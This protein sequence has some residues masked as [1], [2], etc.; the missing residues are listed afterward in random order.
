LTIFV[1]VLFLPL[2]LVAQNSIQTISGRVLAEHPHTFDIKVLE[3]YGYQIEQFK[4]KA[5]LEGSMSNGNISARSIGNLNQ[6]ISDLQQ[7]SKGARSNLQIDSLSNAGVAS[8]PYIIT[9]PGFDPITIPGF[10]PSTTPG[11]G[12][13]KI[14]ELDPKWQLGTVPRW[15]PG[16]I[17]GW[18]P[19]EIGI[20][21]NTSPPFRFA[22]S[23]REN[24]RNPID[25]VGINTVETK[26]WPIRSADLV[27]EGTYQQG[28][29]QYDENTCSNVQISIRKIENRLKLN[30]THILEF[31]KQ[32]DL[33][34]ANHP[35]D[36]KR[37][38]QAR[39][40]YADKCLRNLTV[41]SSSIREQIANSVGFFASLENSN[42]ETFCS[43]SIVDN[44]VVLTARHCFFDA[45]SPN[46]SI[47]NSKLIDNTIRFIPHKLVKNE[48]ITK[49]EWSKGFLLDSNFIN[50]SPHKFTNFEDFIN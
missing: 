39:N 6:A 8:E 15:E 9:I 29:I 36:F 20:S 1:F 7:Y 49:E 22:T 48:T 34:A 19:Q 45:E 5:T 27:I 40:D 28:Y 21:D 37:Y 41:Y 26:G 47:F 16:T 31:R 32:L 3:A 10:D 44:L 18:K 2:E 38:E 24:R 25:M 35:S 30:P 46:K 17:P 50:S 33:L 42:V 14:H 43:G 11:L 13:N 4:S 23:T 12:L